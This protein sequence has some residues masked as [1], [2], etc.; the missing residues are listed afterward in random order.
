MRIPA[1]ARRLYWV[2]N[3]DP[4]G[5]LGDYSGYKQSDWD[6]AVGVAQELVSDGFWHDGI[7][8]AEVLELVVVRSLIVKAPEPEPEDDE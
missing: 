6:E 8:A 4:E 2:Q 7:E 5:D 1:D 3:A